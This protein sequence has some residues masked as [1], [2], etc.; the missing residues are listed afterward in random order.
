MM[1]N[2]DI[3][4]HFIYVMHV[5]RDWFIHYPPLAP[6]YWGILANTANY[7]ANILLLLQCAIPHS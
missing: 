7:S 4:D 6:I 5:S 1:K 3:F 2:V